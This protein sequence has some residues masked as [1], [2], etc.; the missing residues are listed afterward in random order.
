MLPIAIQCALV[1]AYAAVAAWSAVNSVLEHPG[2][3]LTFR[4][5]LIIA[6]VSQFW[7]VF[8]GAALLALTLRFI[9]A[10]SVMPGRQRAL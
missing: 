3:R 7:I 8:Y 9:V 4:D 5:A 6:I 10:A 1:F 2:D